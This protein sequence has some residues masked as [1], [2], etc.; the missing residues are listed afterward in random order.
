MG[1]SVAVKAVSPRRAAGS[2]G[3]FTEKRT[4]KKNGE[5]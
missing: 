2:H 1:A 3:D 5:E 4:E